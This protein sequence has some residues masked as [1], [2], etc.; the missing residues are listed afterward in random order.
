MSERN[1]MLYIILTS[2]HDW[3]GQGG[4]DRRDMADWLGCSKPTLAKKV[5]ELI[6]CGLVR[7]YKVP[8]PRGYG[9]KYHYNLTIEGRLYCDSN[10]DEIYTQYKRWVS[11]KMEAIVKQA[12]GIADTMPVGKRSKK[13]K[14]HEAK[15]EAKL[16]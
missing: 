1:I 12:R 8:T 11:L 14:E 2:V 16:L 5:K 6:A 3:T 4:V 7:E 15:Y 9:W 10:H 13:Q